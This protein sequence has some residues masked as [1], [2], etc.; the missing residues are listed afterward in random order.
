M[1]QIIYAV[2]IHFYYAIIVLLFL[3]LFYLLIDCKCEIKLFI[4]KFDDIPST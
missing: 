3:N 2:F 1:E 4:I